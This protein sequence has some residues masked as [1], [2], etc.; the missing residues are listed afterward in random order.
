MDK[1][2]SSPFAALHAH[3]FVDQ[4]MLLV[5]SYKQRCLL[6]HFIEI[7]EEL[8]FI[9]AKHLKHFWAEMGR[10]PCCGR[11]ESYSSIVW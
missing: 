1:K 5:K 10:K 11:P 7:Q 8:R 6:L 4:G 3:D 2:S 9:R